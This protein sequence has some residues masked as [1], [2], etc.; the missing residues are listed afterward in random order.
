MYQIDA[1]PSKIMINSGI[2]DPDGGRGHI[3]ASPTVIISTYAYSPFL[4]FGQ[5]G[6]GNWQPQDSGVMPL[7]KELE[8]TK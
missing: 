4:D 8:I 6:P 7:T 5:N 2:D 1:Q 3:S